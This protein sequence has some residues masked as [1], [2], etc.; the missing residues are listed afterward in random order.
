MSYEE[1]AAP[2]NLL[3]V[4]DEEDVQPMFRQA[5]RRDVRRGRYVLHF[6]TSGLEALE[7]LRA[8]PGIDLV[9]TDINMPEMDGLALLGELATAQLDLRAVVL[10]AYG[11]MSNIRTAMSLGAVDFVTKPVD[12]DDMAETIDRTLRNLEQWRAVASNRSRLASLQRE[13]EIAAQIQRSVL[14]VGVPMA[15]GYTL[16]AYLDPAQEV[17]GDFYDFL[18]FQ[19]GRVGLV[20]ADVCGKGIPAAMVM[21]STRTM[22]RGAAI[23]TCDPAAILAE[24]NSLICQNNP[25]AMFV[26]AFVCILDTRSA[27][28][29]YSVAGHPPA[30][31]LGADGRV[32]LL[33]QSVSPALGLMAASQYRNVVLEMERGDVL[34]AY[35]DGV[36]EAEDGDGRMFGEDRLLDL[37]RGGDLAGADQVVGRLRAVLTDFGGGA[38]LADDVTV[39]GV[40]RSPA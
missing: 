22:L 16:A 8:E 32:V 26:T 30:L 13:L 15:P 4:D 10:S 33:D 14:P 19:D 40:G 24:V 20:V 28:L 38:P 36:I 35:T 25:L 2:H 34:M 9:I 29:E 21:M 11:D 3:I 39:V 31:L 7:V 18:S 6:A 17:A 23:G 12:F 27:T 1:G 5:M 37:F